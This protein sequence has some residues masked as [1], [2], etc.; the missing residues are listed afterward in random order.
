MQYFKR[1]CIEMQEGILS[2]QETREY[3]RHFRAAILNLAGYED[4]I[5]RRPSVIDDKQIIHCLRFLELASRFPLLYN[6]QSPYEHT[7]ITDTY[8][9]LADIESLDEG[10]RMY[11]NRF[12]DIIHA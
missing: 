1:L 11:L 3:T 8:N 10:Y 9:I 12:R 7:L 5:R 4:I 6:D 2:N